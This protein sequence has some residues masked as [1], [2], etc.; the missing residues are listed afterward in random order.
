[1]H[2]ESQERKTTEKHESKW[3]DELTK[4]EKE[5]ADSKKVSKRTRSEGRNQEHGQ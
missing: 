1:M 3:E 5:R 2:F 4:K